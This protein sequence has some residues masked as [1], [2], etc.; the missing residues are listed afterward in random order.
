M[1][2]LF[3]FMDIIVYIC[4]GFAFLTWEHSHQGNEVYCQLK[5]NKNYI[6]IVLIVI[7]LIIEVSSDDLVNKKSLGLRACQYLE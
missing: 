1:C 6:Y 4:F 2:I 5:I 3:I 7:T